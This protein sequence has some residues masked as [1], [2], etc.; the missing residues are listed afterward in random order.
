MI[1]R[2]YIYIYIFVLFACNPCIESMYNCIDEIRNNFMH[3]K[4]SVGEMAKL[5]P[6][7]TDDF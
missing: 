2:V 1:R 6:T 7:D 4:G 3:N 5:Y